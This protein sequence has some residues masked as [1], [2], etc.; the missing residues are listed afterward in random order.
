MSVLM[1]SLQLFSKKYQYS[2][3]N[4]PPTSI[5]GQISCIILVLVVLQ[6]YLM[7]TRYMRYCEVPHNASLKVSHV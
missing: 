4:T 5:N 6:S 2:L 3:H 1:K 7:L